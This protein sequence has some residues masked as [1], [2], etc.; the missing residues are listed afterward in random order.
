M[1][2]RSQFYMDGYILSSATMP[3]IHTMPAAIPLYTVYVLKWPKNLAS[4]LVL[5]QPIIQ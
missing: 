5:S 2:D 4:L 3:T 1:F